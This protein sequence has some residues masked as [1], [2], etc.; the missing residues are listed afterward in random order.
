MISSPNE[1]DKRLVSRL[2]N[3]DVEAFDAIFQ[4]YSDKLFRF[5]FSLLKNEE[6]SK[7]IVQEVFFRIWNKRH[8]ID[9][10]KS[11]KSYLFTISY[12]LIIDQLRLKLKEQQYRKFL[13][14]Y[15][16]ANSDEIEN[17]VD[18]ESLIKKL[19]IVVEELPNKRKQI[20]KLSREKGYSHKEIAEELG[21]SVKTIENQINLSLKHL[22]LRLGRDVLPLLLFF[23]VFS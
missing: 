2:R 21:L 13:Q 10:S 12:N 6:D 20:Y 19:E 18:F 8:E 23:A 15:F 4:K 1:N 5:S 22:K 3:D 14:S 17:K 9:S 11:F 16:N 7:E